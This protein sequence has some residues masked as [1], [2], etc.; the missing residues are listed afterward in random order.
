MRKHAE[1]DPARRHLGFPSCQRPRDVA[2]LCGGL[3]LGAANGSHPSG[4]RP[5]DVSGSDG[6]ETRNGRVEKFKPIQTARFAIHTLGHVP[7]FA[8]PLRR[9]WKAAITRHSTPNVGKAAMIGPSP[10][11][12]G[13]SGHS[14]RR[15]PVSDSGVSG[16]PEVTP[17]SVVS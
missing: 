3:C 13:T 6:F 12:S 16:H 8:T 9:V 4:S 14:F 1:G 10:A 5:N 15:H 17:L 7:T 2:R 11:H